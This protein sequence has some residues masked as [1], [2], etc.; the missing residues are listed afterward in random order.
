M[1]QISFFGA[2]IRGQVNQKKKGNTTSRIVSSFQ[3]ET[4]KPASQLQLKPIRVNSPSLGSG[5][6]FALFGVGCTVACGKN[7]GRWHHQLSGRKNKNQEVN[8]NYFTVTG[9]VSKESI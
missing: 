7:T 4:V 1:R 5:A 9:R 8:A 2:A 6:I 3:E